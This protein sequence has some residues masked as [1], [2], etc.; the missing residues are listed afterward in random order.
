MVMSEA[1]QTADSRHS[2]EGICAP[3]FA[4]CPLC[5]GSGEECV[6]TDYGN[7]WDNPPEAIFERC[8]LCEGTGRAETKCEALTLEDLE[9]IPFGVSTDAE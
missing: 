2:N 5:D 1:K 4:P 9:T 6:G 8:H 3:I 7:R